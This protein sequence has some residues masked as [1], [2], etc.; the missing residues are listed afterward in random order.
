MLEFS[1]IEVEDAKITF[2][3]LREAGIFP[4]RTRWLVTGAG[5]FLGSQ[6]LNVLREAKS[7]SFDCEI[8]VIDSNIR[9]NAR[10]WYFRGAQVVKLDVIQPWPNL[11]EFTHILHLA[12]IASPVYYRKF[13]LETLQSNYLGTLNALNQAR[14]Q[15]ANLL[16]MS[17]SE[18]YGDPT[19]ENIPTLETY[20]GNVSSIG[21][22]ACYDEGKR[23]M[24]TLAWI[25]QS[26]NN[27]NIAI[28]RPFNFYGPGMRL[29]D[30]RILPDM[31]NSIVSDLDIV[32]YSDGK[33]TRSFCY[34]RDAVRA[35]FQMVLN[36]KAWKLYNVGNSSTE[37]SMFELATITGEIAQSLG[38]AGK[39]R[40]EVPKE[41]DYLIN[42]PNR[43]MPNTN[44]IKSELSWAAEVD[45]KT[46][47]TRSI[48]HFMELSK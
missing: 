36:N 12:S 28:A 26:Q 4:Q 47:I 46:G 44:L 25:F 3:S 32:L 19:P 43:R 17:S 14:E 7:Q 16:L 31:F 39:I 40:Y 10:E 24:E 1:R 5:G 35:L 41:N 13:P 8:V 6:I 11:G 33:P 38:W 34:V 9:G 23:V 18:I 22:R 30:R 37:I 20:R 21:P 42:N 45:L 29:D 48:K 2:N 15:G 27:M